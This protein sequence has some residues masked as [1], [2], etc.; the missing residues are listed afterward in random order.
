MTE[1]KTAPA[2]SRAAKVQKVVTE[3]GIEAWLVEDYAVPLVAF[4]FAF[5]A[6]AV[7]DP[8]G[9]A[10]AATMLAGMLDEGAGDLDAGAFHRALDD[11]AVEISFNAGHDSFS[12]DMKTLVRHLDDAFDLLRLAVN[13]PRFDADAIERTRSQMIAGLRHE[14]NDPDAMAARAWRQMTF[15]DHPYGRP[16]R[17]ELDTVPAIARDDLVALHGKLMARE[18]IRIAVV[19]AIDA[20]TLARKIDHVFAGLPAT[21]DVISVPDVVPASGVRKVVDLD[22]PQTTIRFSLPGIDRHDPE[23]FS[24]FMLNHIL[25]GGVFAAR[26][27]KEVREKRG[28]AYSVWSQLQSLEH[29]AL[30]IG[31]TSTKNERAA[32]SVQVIEEEIAKLVA[33]GPTEEEL[34]KAKKFLIGSYALR[35]DTSTK[36]AGNLVHLQMEGFPVEFLDERNDRI[37]EV[38][39]EDTRKAAKRLFEGKKLLIAAAGRPVGF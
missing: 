16:V 31:S 29:A 32:E 24:A 34:E 22:V 11:K 7:N 37:A 20:E 25:G 33:D 13:E 9:K 12:G 30:F 26:L 35:F 10:G 36:I 19:G 27:F 4:D 2:E 38:T 18:R 23:F 17:G 6:G 3:S 15:G 28:L 1:L 39:L 8:Q 5:K 21:S 14:T